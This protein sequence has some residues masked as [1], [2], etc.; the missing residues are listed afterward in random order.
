VQVVLLAAMHSE[1]GG[2]QLEDEPAAAAVD[3]GQLQHVAEEFAV[4]LRVAGEDHDMGAGDHVGV[5]SMA[6]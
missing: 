3:A 5:L 1:L 4:R 2:R 6:S